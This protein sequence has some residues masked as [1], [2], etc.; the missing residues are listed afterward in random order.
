M[1]RGRDDR[2]QYLEGTPEFPAAAVVISVDIW[3]FAFLH[4]A[5]KVE[6]IE[7]EIEFRCFGRG[8]TIGVSTARSFALCLGQTQASFVKI[9][10]DDGVF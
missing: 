8:A 9:R 10:M 2:N 3:I 6:K 5:I 4:A 7:E 1:Q